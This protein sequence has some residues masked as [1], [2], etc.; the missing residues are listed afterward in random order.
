MDV[1]ELTAKVS[2]VP[3]V[4]LEQ[5]KFLVGRQIATTKTCTCRFMTIR[6][7]KLKSGKSRLCYHVIA[8][9]V[10]SMLDHGFK[11]YIIG[12]VNNEFEYHP[13]K[14]VNV[15]DFYKIGFYK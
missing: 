15:D 3:I 2:N 11:Q 8:V 4:K 14:V 12:N 5:N 1:N 6:R 9:I 7:G 13:D 10:W